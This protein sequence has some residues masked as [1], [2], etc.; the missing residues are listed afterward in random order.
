MEVAHTT[1]GPVR[2][3]HQVSGGLEVLTAHDRGTQAVLLTSP[4]GGGKGLMICDQIAQ[5]V[6][7][8]WHAILYTN[9]KLLLEQLSGVLTAAGIGHGIRASGYRNDRDILVQL[10][11]IPTEQARTVKS[12]KW[13]LH[14]DGKPCLAVIDEAHLNKADTA[15]EL[16]RRHKEAGHRILGVTATPLGLGHLYDKLVIAGTVSELRACG[17]LV[18]AAVY[19]P[20]EPDLH[21]FEAKLGRGEDLSEDV[22]RKSM[23]GDKPRHLFGRVWEWWNALNKRRRPTILF[24]PGVPESRWFAEQ[25]CAKGVPFAHIDG[26]E[27][28]ID[29]ETWPASSESRAELLAR[30]EGGKI[31]GVCNRF[32]LREGIDTK[33]AEHLILATVF[34]SSMS[35]LQSVG[36]GLRASPVTG[37]TR[38]VIQDH[39]G[40][41]HRHGSPNGD[42]QWHIDDT[43][44]IVAGLRAER[45]REKADTE[46]MRC[47]RCAQILNRRQCPCGYMVDRKVRPVVTS[48]GRMMELE[49]DI[50]VRRAREQKVDT[51]KL[52]ASVYWRAKNSG[53]MTFRQAEGLFYKM[54]GY[55]PP[56]TLAWMPV[57][58]IDWFNRVADIPQSRLTATSQNITES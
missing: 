46:P 48:D 30:F 50:Y 38:C 14:G 47:P 51:E 41:W 56:K 54:H 16:I 27:V 9:R 25:F 28:W 57:A 33:W 36:R 40:N 39:G 17:A 3:P 12:N 26:E 43:P 20:D 52:W 5:R 55:W 11:S 1:T 32:V 6:A 10:S 44:G 21:Q 7:E 34:G 13:P 42:R 15:A 37:K 24:A 18:P 22:I 2:W 31:V 8:E 49:G 35:Y 4:T 45:L 53:N 29:G 19:G 58:D 23:G